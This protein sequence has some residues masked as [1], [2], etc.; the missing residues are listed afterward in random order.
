MSK[1]RT[2][3]KSLF[4]FNMSSID[5]NYTIFTLR[6]YAKQPNVGVIQP[7]ENK[8]ILKEEAIKN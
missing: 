6:Y 7:F 1:K 5:W 4:I 3:K 8:F 2:K